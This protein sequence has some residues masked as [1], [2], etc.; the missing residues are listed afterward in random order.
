MGGSFPLVTGAVGICTVSA[1]SD[2]GRPWF[3]SL[4][5]L[6]GG[7]AIFD[8]QHHRCLPCSRRNGDFSPFFSAQRGGRIWSSQTF[9]A[10]SGV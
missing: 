2:G 7:R 1:P 4:T 6:L 3:Y 9:P 10:S 5:A 8:V